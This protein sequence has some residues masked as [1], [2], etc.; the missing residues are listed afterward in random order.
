MTGFNTLELGPA[1]SSF[2]SLTPQRS[3]SENSVS[4]YPIGPAHSARPVPQPRSSVLPV[5]HS[6]NLSAANNDSDG[7]WDWDK[8]SSDNTLT[9]K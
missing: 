9:S 8:D 1:H 3:L 6:P 2:E 5:P 7:D 4:T